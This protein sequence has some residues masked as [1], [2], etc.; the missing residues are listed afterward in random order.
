MINGAAESQAYQ[1]VTLEVIGQCDHS[2]APVSDTDSANALI[3]DHFKGIEITWKSFGEYLSRLE[4]QELGVNVIAMV[5]Q[6]TIRQ[7]VMK[8]AWQPA[9]PAETDQMVRLLEESL[10]AG[11]GGFST[12]L[13]YWLGR[14]STPEEIFPLCEVAARRN[15]LYTTHVRDRDTYYDIGFAEALSL[16][17]NSGVKLQ[18]SHC[19][20]GNTF[21]TSPTSHAREMIEQAKKS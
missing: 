4:Q 20:H 1:G 3:P 12:G 6:G 7:V 10:E 19:N 16:A 13:E 5:G 11:A 18:I 14:S 21:Y 9:T 15:A 17:R 2:L 8:D